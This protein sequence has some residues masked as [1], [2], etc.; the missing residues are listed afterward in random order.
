MTVFPYL[1]SKDTFE[2]IRGS[3]KL[4]TPR[5]LRFLSPNA[6]RSFYELK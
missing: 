2:T 3:T 4:Q 1:K 5:N 6:E